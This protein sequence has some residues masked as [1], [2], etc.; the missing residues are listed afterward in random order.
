[1]NIKKWMNRGA[2]VI[3]VLLL[4]MQILV[5]IFPVMYSYCVIPCMLCVIVITTWFIYTT[6][7]KEN[8]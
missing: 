5:P 6:H 2:C 8:K 1:M 7:A 3:G 4:L